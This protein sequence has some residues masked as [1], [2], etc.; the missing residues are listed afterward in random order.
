VRQPLVFARI[1]I[2]G[3]E[4]QE[5]DEAEHAGRPEH[6][7]PAEAQHQIAGEQYADPARE[8]GGGVEQRG[9][10]TA[11][12]AREPIADGLRVGWERR[13]FGDPE[14]RARGEDRR[15]VGRERRQRRGQAPQER[16][17][18]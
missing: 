18:P 2:E 15:E 7:T 12:V 1:A 16:A 3:I 11:L 10:Q 13:R 8:L 9:R 5:E 17:D 6:P 14:K 4:D